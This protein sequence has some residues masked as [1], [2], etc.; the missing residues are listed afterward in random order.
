MARIWRE[1]ELEMPSVVRSQ[2]I[3]KP[4][5]LK[6]MLYSAA[7]GAWSLTELA[8]PYYSCVGNLTAKKIAG[9]GA[10]VIRVNGA[11][12]SVDAAT[13]KMLEVGERLKVRYTRR[14]RTISIDRL[15]DKPPGLDLDS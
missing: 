9:D 8:P 15:V 10:N 13:Y 14:A 3:P 2:A 7:H 1:S 4:N 11:W 5:Q 6:G 12:L